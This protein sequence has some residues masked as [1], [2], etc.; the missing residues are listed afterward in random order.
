MARTTSK[1]NTGYLFEASWEVCN[2]V[3][4]IYTVLSSKAKCLKKTYGDNLIF[5]GPDIWNGQ[6]N[7]WF[8]QDDK[9]LASWREHAQ[10]NDNLPI[11][12]GRWKVEGKPIAILIDFKSLLPHK[13]DIYKQMWED[14]QVNSLHAYGDYD[15]SS[16]FA[17][18]TGKA[19][20]SFYKFFKLDT[21]PVVAHFNEWML[22]MGLLYVKKHLPKVATVFT[23]HAT[24][25]GRSIAGNHKPLYSQLPN[26]NGDQMAQEL[27]IEAKHSVE[28][29]AAHHADCFTTVSDITATECAFLLNKK[30]LVTPNGFEQDIVPKDKK[31]SQARTKARKTLTTVAEKL[32]GQ[33]ISKEA[34]LIATSGRYE[35]KNKGIDVFIDALGK[36]QHHPDLKRE[37][38]AFIMI[39]AWTKEPRKDLQER[40]QNKRKKNIEPLD[41]PIITHRLH[42]M[43][44]DPILQQIQYLGIQNQPNTPIKVIF[45]PCYLN[46]EDGIFNTPYYDLLVGLDLT[47]FPSYYEPWGYT[48][49]ESIA[50]SVPTITTTLAGFGI[51]NQHK[52]KGK[53]HSGVTVIQRNDDNFNEVSEEICRL[54]Y[55]YT[56]KKPEEIAN[57]Q[58][59]ASKRALLAD[60][61]HF[62][63]FYE[64]AYTL[65]LKE[66][67]K[68]NS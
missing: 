40:L 9:L 32:L 3:G 61:E 29:Q 64:K 42:H 17:Y 51:W 57:I 36:L 21:T 50:F 14:F 63:T 56:L 52:D 46:G 44:Q 49:H 1:K 39:P 12:I 10:T 30:P 20:E 16:M 2:K 28:K 6:D 41:H 33:T 68:R 31:Y 53:Q 34:L 13:N 5:I 60:W 22:G 43:E 19:I 37:I 23:T 62:I 11:R 45:V 26:Y 59:A 48:P 25:I 38:V 66:A 35:Y 58:N 18:A 47:I 55:E 7:I 15:E 54:I 8:K 24:S 67:H 27:N 4:G 65:A